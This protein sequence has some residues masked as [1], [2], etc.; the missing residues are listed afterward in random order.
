MLEEP[1]FPKARSEEYLQELISGAH[2][3]R[4]ARRW[5]PYQ[6]LSRLKLPTLHVYSKQDVYYSQCK[7]L[8]DLCDTARR[9]VMEHQEG[10]WIPKSKTTSQKIGSAI[11]SIL[12]H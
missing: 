2:A 12:S 8:V 10:H 1:N 4:L 11:M 7:D 6:D 3:P 5:T 9:T